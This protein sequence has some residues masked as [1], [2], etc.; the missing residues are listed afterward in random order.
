MPQ[1][2]TEAVLHAKQTTVL[3]GPPPPHTH[4]DAS[5]RL[6]RDSGSM[7]RSLGGGSKF[8]MQSVAR[9]NR[10]FPLF[11]KQQQQQQS[12]AMSDGTSR[13]FE[14]P[15]VRF[16]LSHTHPCRHPAI[17]QSCLLNTQCKHPR[18]PVCMSTQVYRLRV[19]AWGCPNQ[20]SPTNSKPQ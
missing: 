20:L 16:Q 6:P 1:A 8:G 3:Q 14:E 12:D 17:Q 5:T 11:G 10:C 9:A 18:R 4:T 15:R 7:G 19:L 13:D 2:T